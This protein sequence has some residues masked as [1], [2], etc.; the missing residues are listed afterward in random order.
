MS[1]S[2]RLEICLECSKPFPYHAGRKYCSHACRRAKIN[3]K[4]REKS[5]LQSSRSLKKFKRTKITYPIEEKLEYI[6][7]H[8]CS[9]S[10][11]G[12]SEFPTSIDLHHRNPKEKLFALGSIRGKK[13]HE[14]SWEDLRKE[15]EKCVPLCACC[16]RAV[17]ANLVKI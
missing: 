16:H 2:C 9:C 14:T 7:S 12:Y 10:R 5:R 17:S 3:R 4:S 1:E 11:C 13:L 6:N 8:R 15:V